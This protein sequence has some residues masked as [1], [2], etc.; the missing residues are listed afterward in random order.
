MQQRTTLWISKL[1]LNYAAEKLAKI[2]PSIYPVGSIWKLQPRASTGGAQQ[3]Y[4][5]A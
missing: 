5:S 2:Q 4:P 3:F 1:S